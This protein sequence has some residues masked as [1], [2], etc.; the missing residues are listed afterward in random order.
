MK[1][2]SSQLKSVS[3]FSWEIASLYCRPVLMIK[4]RMLWDSALNTQSATQMERINS[5][6]HSK[7]NSRLC[8]K[9]FRSNVESVERQALASTA[10]LVVRI[11]RFL[12]WFC[13]CAVSGFH[14]DLVRPAFVHKHY[15]VR[16]IAKQTQRSTRFAG[17][18][19]IHHC[20]NEFTTQ[21]MSKFLKEVLVLCLRWRVLL[22]DQGKFYWKVL[23]LRG[24][25]SEFPMPPGHH[26]VCWLKFSF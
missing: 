21:H 14:Q 17:D 13:C 12:W 25:H 4:G 2:K 20:D 5:L 8:P 23:P 26:S 7:H 16:L 10:L 19:C 3:G 9:Q 22:P 18:I 6:P 15:T 1:P 24:T 11:Q